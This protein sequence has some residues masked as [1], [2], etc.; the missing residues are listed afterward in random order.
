[1]SLDVRKLLTPFYFG[2]ISDAERLVVERELLIDSETLVDYLDLKRKIEFATEIPA[3]PS[4]SVWRRLQAEIKPR[5]KLVLTLSFAV[6]LA[7]SVMIAAMFFK[8]P[9]SDLPMTNGTPI[10]FDSGN[11]QSGGSSVL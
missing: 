3:E 9:T 1:M 10:L 11:E 4:P 7:A 6:G 2:S 8:K 5:R